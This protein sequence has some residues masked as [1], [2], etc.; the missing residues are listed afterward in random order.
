MNVFMNQSFNMISL[1]KN[2][3][4]SAFLGA[5]SM[6]AF[7]R[8]V[9]IRPCAWFTAEWAKGDMIMVVMDLNESKWKY[10]GLSKY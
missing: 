10:H 3:T 1:C 5:S 9:R 7:S 2:V 8:Y 4:F 6:D